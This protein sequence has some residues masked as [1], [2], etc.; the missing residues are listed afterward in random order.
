MTSMHELG[1]QLIE[2]L[3]GREYEEPTDVV[4]LAHDLREAFGGNLT[5]A[6][7]EAGIDRRT[8]QRWEARR[9]GHRQV[10][11]PDTLLRVRRAIR[12]QLVGTS[13]TGVTDNN[14]TL[15][16]TDRN[17][18]NRRPR[19]I[20]GRQL[21]LRPGTMTNLETAYERGERPEDI[22]RQFVGS[23]R[24]VFYRNF[25]GAADPDSDFHG[26]SYGAGSVNILTA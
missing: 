7:R 23:I 16:A 15:T 11:K 8:L 1:L 9:G 12:E 26:S 22:A 25:I 10:P 3:T 13:S 17:D 24:N 20:M 5:R 2:A 19:N 21:Q 14:I 4:E 18:P 6:A